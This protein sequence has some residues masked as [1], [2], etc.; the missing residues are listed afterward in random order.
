MYQKPNQQVGRPTPFPPGGNVAFF[1]SFGYELDLSDCHQ[2][3]WKIKEQIAFYKQIPLNLP[4]WNL[5]CLP[6]SLWGEDVAFPVGQRWHQVIVGFY[7]RLE[8]ANLGP[9]RTSPKGTRTAALMNWTEKTYYGS[10]LMYVGL[11]STTKSMF[12]RQ[13]FSS[14]L[15]FSNE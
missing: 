14:R 2:M 9:A 15:T 7:R 4:I 3:S 11:R 6:Q 10:D 5:T 13:G 12:K 1:G 8:T